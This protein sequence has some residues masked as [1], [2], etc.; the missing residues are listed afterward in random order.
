MRHT[1]RHCYWDSC[2][3]KGQSC[4][5]QAHSSVHT[6][7]YLTCQMLSFVQIHSRLSKLECFPRTYT[8]HFVYNI[9]TATNQIQGCTIPRVTLKFSDDPAV[10]SNERLFIIQDNGDKWRLEW[11]SVECLARYVHKFLRDAVFPQSGTIYY[12]VQPLETR[13]PAP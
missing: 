3:D 1:T 10:W 5:R 6:K 13:T 2:N 11:L 9:W 8:E 12:H 7:R 4:E